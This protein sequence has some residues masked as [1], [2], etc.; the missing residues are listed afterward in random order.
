MSRKLYRDFDKMLKESDAQIS[1][2]NGAK[3]LSTLQLKNS[4]PKALV[5]P[6]LH[7]MLVGEQK[8]KMRVYL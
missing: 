4:R 6:C 2:M 1:E 7:S 5:T 8:V 3:P